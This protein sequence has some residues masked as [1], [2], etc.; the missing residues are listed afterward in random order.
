MKMNLFRKAKSVLLVGLAAAMFSTSAYGVEA[1]SNVDESALS[2]IGGTYC[3]DAITGEVTFIPDD[4]TS[5]YS[6]E[7][8]LNS[9]SYDPN[10]EQIEINDDKMLRYI[11][12]NRQIIKNPQNDARYCTTV[13]ISATTAN[14]GKLRGSG[15]MIGPNAVATAGHVLF[16]KD[17]FGGD[18][19]ITSATITPAKNTTE[20]EPHFG[21][22]SAIAYRC[23]GDWA[24]KSDYNDDWGIIILNRDIGTQTGLM[25]KH[26]QSAAYSN[27][28]VAYVNGYPKLVGSSSVEQFDLYTSFGSISSSKS[29]KLHSKD[30]YMSNGD[31]GGPCYIISKTYGYQAIG[32]ASYGI[33]DENN[34]KNV[35]ETVFRWIDQTLYN[36]LAKYEKSTL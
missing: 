36:K 34:K 11:K 27:D 14:G 29:K 35:Y 16:D 21:T 20:T 22:A 13:Y 25:G 23:G 26:S 24:R 6:E 3:K 19:W 28:T 17:E 4:E 15:F 30:I 18:G 5:T 7:F 31:S 12:D 2:L 32:I 1:E 9:P 10:N 33:T 8:E